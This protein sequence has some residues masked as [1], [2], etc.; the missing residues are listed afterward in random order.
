M[1]ASGIPRRM[2]LPLGLEP[3]GQRL[4]VLRWRSF[5]SWQTLIHPR[6]KRNL[7]M[8]AARVSPLLPGLFAEALRFENLLP[9]ATRALV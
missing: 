7:G 6:N 1:P 5:S 2:V 3:R 9:T 8:S 4:L